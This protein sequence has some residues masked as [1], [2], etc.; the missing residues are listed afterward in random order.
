M[1][2]FKFAFS[3]LAII[4][5]SSSSLLSACLNYHT[6]AVNQSNINNR[7]ANNRSVSM[8]LSPKALSDFNWRL[9]SATTKKSQSMTILSN[10]KNQIK[11][12]FYL[13]QGRHNIDLTVGCNGM[14]GE[15]SLRNNHFKVKN[16]MSTEMYCS[17]ELNDAEKLMQQLMTMES[18]LNL[19]AST[20]QDQH[21]AILTQHLKTGETLIWQ[22][23][24]T[25]EARYQQNADIVFWQIDHQLQ[26]CPTTNLRKCLKVR[27]VYFNDQ[28]IKQG[29]GD[30]EL[31]VDGI[32][33]Y[34]HNSKTDSVLRL[35]RFTVDPVD[36]KGK[37]F[38][39]DLDQIIETTNVK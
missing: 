20:Q 34:Q 4:I 18:T 38:V 19:E 1:F 21:Q 13:Y 6:T 12:N 39:Y 2:R 11:L 17:D 7:S 14:G 8:Q 10:I 16:I 24:A 23:V 28:G 29:V 35:K 15:F 22:G 9:S 37:Q 25:P 5:I 3:R 31:F 27:P 33:G 32:E 30:W 26:V 36:V